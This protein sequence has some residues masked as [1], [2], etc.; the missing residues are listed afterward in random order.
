MTD[1]NMT[2]PPAPAP[3]PVK[4]EKTKR[5]IAIRA[6]LHV[7][8]DVMA[9]SMEQSGNEAECIAFLKAQLG[10]DYKKAIALSKPKKKRVPSRADRWADA[11]GRA[12]DAFNE[13][14]EIQSELQ[15]WKDN[16]DG[17][18]EGSA[19]VEKLDFICDLDIEGAQSTASDANGAD[20]PLGFGRD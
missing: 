12:E 5:M 8:A 18:F 14:Q 11:A 4:P 17:K 9:N 7:A 19:L 6:V 15:E 1:N 20:F 10:A 13:L 2:T 16:L 3:E